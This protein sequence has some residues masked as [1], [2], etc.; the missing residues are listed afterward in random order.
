MHFG[1]KWCSSRQ[2]N[3]LARHD[4]LD[5][6]TFEILQGRRILKFVTALRCVG[7]SKMRP[8]RSLKKFLDR[9]R[10]DE[11]LTL[12]RKMRLVCVSALAYFAQSP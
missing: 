6:V 5:F 7:V 12:P 10:K 1:G 8:S 9:P 11:S 3:R 4:S 2:I